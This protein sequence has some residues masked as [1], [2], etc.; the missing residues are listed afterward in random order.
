MSRKDRDAIQL[1]GLQGNERGQKKQE[2][3]SEAAR[4]SHQLALGVF[5]NMIGDTSKL[6]NDRR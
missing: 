2:R 3:E 1:F 4:S 6:D 5:I